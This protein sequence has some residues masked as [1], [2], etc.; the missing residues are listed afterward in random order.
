MSKN[1]IKI[2]NNSFQ[3]S[4]EKQRAGENLSQKNS[5][6]YFTPDRDL[7]KLPSNNNHKSNRIRAD[8]VPPISNKDDDEFFDKDF[9]A[10]NEK[11][12]KLRK[13]RKEE[14]RR[15]RKSPSP[16][17]LNFLKLANF[18]QYF[19]IILL[20]IQDG[21]SKSPF[22]LESLHLNHFNPSTLSSFNLLSHL[23][24]RSHESVTKHLLKMYPA[25]IDYVVGSS[26]ARLIRSPMFQEIERK[27]VSEN[28]IL[29]NPIKKSF[30]FDTIS[31]KAPFLTIVQVS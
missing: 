9:F 12:K 30:T 29:F 25:P 19:L 17:D 27:Y 10:Q 16:L 22:L 26:S 14:R 28:P 13:K 11:S 31:P 6:Q 4:V 21:I 23:T 5:L 3:N 8:T 18:L 20:R 24:Q 7:I 2:I 15:R 1:N